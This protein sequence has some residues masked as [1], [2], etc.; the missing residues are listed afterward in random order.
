[1]AIGLIE[2]MSIT[3]VPFFRPSA[4][5]FGAEQDRLHVGRVGHHEDDHLGPRGD[6]SSASATTSAAARISS[7]RLARSGTIEVVA[8][9]LQVQRHGAAHDAEADKSDFHA[10]SPVCLGLSVWPVCL[11]CLSG[12]AAY[13]FGYISARYGFGG[14]V[15]SS[16]CLC[17]DRGRPRG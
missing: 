14:T 11:A 4:T 15:A 5:P 16:I 13:G 9:L 10:V 6:A 8:G 2:D 3:S 7:V 12:V 17:A 1:M